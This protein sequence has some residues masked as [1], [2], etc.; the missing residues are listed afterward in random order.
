MPSSFPKEHLEKCIIDLHYGNISINCSN[1]FGYS[2]ALMGGT[3][4]AHYR[5]KRSGRGRIG[6]IYKVP[7]VTKTILRGKTLETMKMDMLELMET[8]GIHMETMIVLTL[9]WSLVLLKHL[10]FLQV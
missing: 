7:H 1:I 2:S 6:N 3:W 9:L 4:G 8:G 5:D 10:N